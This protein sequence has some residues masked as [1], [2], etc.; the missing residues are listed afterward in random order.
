MTNSY[1]KNKIICQ[2]SVSVLD[3]CCQ[4]ALLTVLGGSIHLH[5]FISIYA[6]DRTLVVSINKQITANMIL[7]RKKKGMW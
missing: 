3:K 4:L 5:W 7:E 1:Q 6:N 2:P